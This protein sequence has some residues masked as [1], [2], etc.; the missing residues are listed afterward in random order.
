[1][2]WEYL[3]IEKCGRHW[4]VNE[5]KD[6]SLSGSNGQAVLNLMGR[7]GWKLVLPL[8]DH[9]ELSFHLKRQPELIPPL[10][11]DPPAMPGV[12]A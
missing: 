9:D 8:R 11:S 2:N 12:Q 10:P 4:H 6:E 7:E 3:V 5:F 1:M